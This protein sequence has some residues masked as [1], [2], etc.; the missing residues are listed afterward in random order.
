MS[1]WRRHL[2]SKFLTQSRRSH[3][4]N[5]NLIVNNNVNNNVFCG[6]VRAFQENTSPNNSNLNLNH[7]VVSLNK[8]STQVGS[9]T[10]TQSKFYSSQ[11][12]PD[13]NPKVIDH[14]T[15]S[16]DFFKPSQISNIVKVP[17]LNNKKDNLKHE[18][19]NDVSENFNF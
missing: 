5:N 1:V 10:S 6:G 18:L 3:T 2:D 19:L 11:G 13:K 14:H 9:K 8:T 17:T 15:Q 12:L 7:P 4:D 16:Q